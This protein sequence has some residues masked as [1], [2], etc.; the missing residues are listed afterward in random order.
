MSQENLKG[1]GG[2]TTVKEASK[3]GGAESQQ[4]E[5]LKFKQAVGKGDQGATV[6]ASSPQKTVT[7]PTKQ[8][9]SDYQS[10]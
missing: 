2:N 8:V 4:T 9:T 3:L 7:S 6:A 1:T 5:Q 10:D